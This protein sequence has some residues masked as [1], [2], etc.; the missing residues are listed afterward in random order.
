MKNNFAVGFI[1][2]LIFFALVPFGCA[3]S[4]SEED[5]ELTNLLFGNWKGENKESL[6]FRADGTFI[7]T[8]FIEVPHVACVF[9]PEFIFEGTF[10]VTNRELL[11]T[12]VKVLF[13][14]TAETNPEIPFHRFINRRTISLLDNELFLQEIQRMIPQ[15]KFEKQPHGYWKAENHAIVYSAEDKIFSFT[16]VSLLFNFNL[17]SESCE[18]KIEFG[19]G[20]TVP[21]LESKFEYASNRIN[22]SAMPDVMALFKDDHWLWFIHDPVRFVKN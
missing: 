20:F 1:L 13:S 10:L 5:L 4:Q 19:N 12:N 21:V 2:L 6:S 17:Q 15:Q 22:F 3:S 11:F 18:R 16:K 7:D 8:L 14:K 9:I